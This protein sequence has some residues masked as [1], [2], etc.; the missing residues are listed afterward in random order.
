MSRTPA[1]MYN[2]SSPLP[3]TKTKAVD[4]ARSK[5]VE[6]TNI[7]VARQITARVILD[8]FGP[9]PCVVPPKNPPM[10]MVIKAVPQS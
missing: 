4:M 3:V 6:A 9:N 2:A 7:N 5:P 10:A 1:V 8:S